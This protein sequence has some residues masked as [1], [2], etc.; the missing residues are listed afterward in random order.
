[1]ETK[2]I[3]AIGYA[4]QNAEALRILYTHYCGNTLEIVRKSMFLSFNYAF[5]CEIFLKGII[6]ITLG[7]KIEAIRGHNLGNLFSMLDSETRKK[8][9]QYFIDEKIIQF[10]EINDDRTDLMDGI[11]RCENVFLETRYFY[12][13]DNANIDFYF[14]MKFS[15]ALEEYINSNTEY[16]ESLKKAKE[17]NNK[18]KGEI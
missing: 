13:G 16:H 11:K 3:V 5:V 9:N 4:F 6:S 7:N 2:T 17:Q 15:F 10:P 18:I 8:I 12:E 14:L 1:M